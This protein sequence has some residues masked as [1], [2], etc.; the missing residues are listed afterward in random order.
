MRIHWKIY[1]QIRNDM[2]KQLVK[3]IIRFLP[4]S[5]QFQSRAMYAKYNDT[6]SA[7]KWEK[8]GRPSPPPDPIKHKIISSYRQQMNCKILV[9]TGTYLG[10]T[11][12]ALR[13]EF[14]RMYSVE[15]A[16]QLWQNAVYRFRNFDHITIV[17]GDSGIVLKDLVPKINLRTL[18]WLDGHYSGGITAKG[19]S[20][21]PIFKELEAIF[22]NNTLGH[23]I[24]I[25][26]ARL[27]NGSND[28]PTIEELHHFVQQKDTLYKLNV[29]DDI[30][31]L[32]K[33]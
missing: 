15:L 26:D 29:Q 16:E 2:M 14:E 17:N 9:E 25:D 24:L 19:E 13:N 22:N 27:F 31:R 20:M 18:F 6:I 30:I 32:V 33:E 28:Y 1:E 8:N 23:V 11:I 21:C 4:K 5:V 7:K 3:S 12:W 10:N